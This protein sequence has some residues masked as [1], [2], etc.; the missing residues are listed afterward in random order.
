MEMQDKV[1]PG[2]TE[3]T[4]G[5]AHRTTGADGPDWRTS[6]D[7]QLDGTVAQVA[8]ADSVHRIVIQQDGTMAVATAGSVEGS[9]GELERRGSPCM[10]DYVADI[11]NLLLCPMSGGL[12][13]SESTFSARKGA[14][15]K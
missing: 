9:N 14:F 6:E 1:T 5:V 4:G 15:R 8:A 13:L 7:S 12:F 2:R 11:W 10:S 3:R